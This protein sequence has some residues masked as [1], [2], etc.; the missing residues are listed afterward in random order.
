MAMD[1]I[2]SSLVPPA[3]RYGPVMRVLSWI[4]LIFLSGFSLLFI[5]RYFLGFAA[6]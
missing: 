4:G 5:A 3:H 6:A 1:T 2:N